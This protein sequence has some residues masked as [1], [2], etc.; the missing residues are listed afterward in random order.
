[1]GG[2][3]IAGNHRNY[4][5]IYF[6]V[7]KRR[8]WWEGKLQPSWAGL[9]RYPEGCYELSNMQYNLCVLCYCLFHSDVDMTKIEE[10]IKKNINVLK[11]RK[12]PN[13]VLLCGIKFYVTPTQPF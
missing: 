4:Y 13:F 8:R 12:S 11:A 5:R 1:M 10:Y 9:D 2:V 7:R 6:G 3:G